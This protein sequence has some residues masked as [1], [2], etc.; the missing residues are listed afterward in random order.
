M[1]PALVT[2]DAFRAALGEVARRG[3]PFDILTLPR[4]LPERILPG[5]ERI[6]ADRQTLQHFP[7]RLT[8]LGDL[9]DRV[10]LERIAELAAAHS[11]L[12]ASKLAQEASATHG[13]LHVKSRAHHQIRR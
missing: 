8:P 2:S 1:T 3:V 9:R 10:P 6:G 13:A 12:R 7:D 5:A 4:H 11:D